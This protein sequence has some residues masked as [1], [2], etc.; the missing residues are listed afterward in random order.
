MNGSDQ[1]EFRV[2]PIKNEGISLENTYAVSR[3]GARTTNN[4]LQVVGHAGGTTVAYVTCTNCLCTTR[5]SDELG[6]RAN[7]LERL[8]ADPTT[9]SFAQAQVVLA[10]DRPVS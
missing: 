3:S 8:H 2:G 6:R 10:A 1:Y 5:M 9:P 7:L 4:C